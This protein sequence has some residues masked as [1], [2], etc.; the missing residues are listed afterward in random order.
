MSVF[1]QGAAAVLLTVIMVLALGNHGKQT[2]LLLIL[3][4]CAMLGILAIG[5]LQPVLDFVR[6]LKAVGHLDGGMLQILLKAVGIGLIGELASLICADTGNAALG[7]ALQIL[8]AAV[9]LRLSVP[10]LEQLLQL[11]EQI[12]GEV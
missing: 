2:A 9:I 1:L 8:S 6:H 3:A 5:Y 7:K 11:L 4:V 10:L 12:M